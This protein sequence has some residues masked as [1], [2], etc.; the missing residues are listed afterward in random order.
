M[1]GMEAAIGDS[2][3]QT[4]QQGVV[5]DS[6]ATQA[7]YLAAF[8]AGALH[9]SAVP[10]ANNV[11]AQMPDS[12]AT[13]VHAAPIQ[14]TF[15]PPAHSTLSMP[16]VM[17]GQ[18]NTA[19]STPQ[20]WMPAANMF[21]ATAAAAAAAA[22]ATTITEMANDTDEQV[23][24]RPTFVNAKQYNRILKRRVA[25]GRLEEHYRNQR[26]TDIDERKRKPY[27]YESRHRHAKKRPRGEG[28]RFLSKVCTTYL[29]LC[30]L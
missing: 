24:T 2:N 25:R 11:M 1:N 30:L 19:A 8:H 28:G 4:S 10:L 27:Q 20:L 14:P 3:N 23:A 29:I 5:D 21:Q 13:M 9:A 22:A 18:N 17:S 7:Q 26:A 12:Q 6:A 15:V 16:Q